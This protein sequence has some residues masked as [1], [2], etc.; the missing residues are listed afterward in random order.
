M[1]LYKISIVL[2]LALPCAYGQ[3]DVVDLSVTQVIDSKII[4]RAMIDT[5]II[6]GTREEL[7]LVKVLGNTA[8]LDQK[9]LQMVGHAHIQESLLRVPGV[10]YARGSGQ[11]S[12]PALRSPVLTGAGACGSILSAVDGIPL[13]AAGFCNINELFD[14]HTE[15]AERVEVIRGPGSALFGSNAMH[16]VIN[17]ITPKVSVEPEFALGFEGG[18]H[19]YSRLKFSGS[20]VLGSGIGGSGIGSSGLRGIE[21]KGS[22]GLRADLSMSHE[23]GYRDN[24]GFDQ[25]K[26]TLRHEYS[27]DQIDVTTTLSYTNLNQETAGYVV[28]ANAYRDDDLNDTN[29][30]PEAYRDAKTARVASHIEFQLD[31]ISQVVI[32]PYL[33][34]TD[35]EFLQHFLPGTPLEKNGQKSVGLQTAYFRDLGD[36]LNIVTGVDLEYTDAF[37]KQRQDSLTQGS[38]FLVATIPEGPH[39]NYQVDALMLA[40][41]IHTTWQVAE[42]LSITAGLRY[43]MMDYDYNNRMLTGRTDDNGDACGFGGCRYSRPADRDDRFENWSPKIGVLYNLND[44]RQ[45]YLN[46]AQGFRAPQATE[47]YRL[48]RDQVRADLDPEEIYSAELGLRSLGKLGGLG[49]SNS[50]EKKLNYEINFFLMKKRNVIFRDSD[51]FNVADGETQHRGLELFLAYQLNDQLD[52]SLNASYAE[53]EYKDDRIL[54][55]V[56][57][58]NNEVDSAP[59]HFGSAQLAWHLTNKVRAELEWVHQGSYFTDP[60]NLHEYDGHNL[61]NLRSSWWLTPQWNIV[62]RITN[63]TNRDYAE[64]ADFSNFAGDR[65][66]PGEPRSLYLQIER[67]W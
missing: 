8:V 34:Y 26:L 65:Y 6:T 12:L 17:V 51:F 27:N 64:R 22:H 59:H 60:E 36:N 40:P 3:E 31:D 1:R 62:V 47:L 24:S 33:R 2:F 9:S 50:L 16:G 46:L 66:F 37:L 61:F 38:P 44:N 55:G 11:E 5:V 32:T 52:F 7:P 67:H 53:H 58:D 39:Y 48:Q 42:R 25:Q 21:T 41:F 45:I 13:R 49:K 30:T 28:G 4:D 18:P 54:H 63:L 43:E 10:N 57:I 14:A 20:G 56:A 23:G 15:M 35:M 29:P 19:D